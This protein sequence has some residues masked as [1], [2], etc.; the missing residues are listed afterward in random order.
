MNDSRPF[1]F[2]KL[3]DHDDFVRHNASGPDCRVLDQWLQEGLFQAARHF[4][5][6]WAD[7]YRGAS[8]YQ[9]CLQAD[10]AELMLVGIVWPSHDKSGRK[11]PFVVALRDN[12]EGIVPGMV[13]YVP[14][15]YKGFLQQSNDLASAGMNGLPLSEL[16]SGLGRLSAPPPDEMG[17][18]YQRFQDY[19]DSTTSEIFWARQ[20]GDFEDR[21]KFLLVKNLLD[22]F[23]PLISGRSVRSSLGV[24][25]PLRG[26]NSFLQE[27]ACFWILLGSQLLRDLRLFPNVLWGVPRVGERTYL[28]FFVNR[29]PVKTLIPML[30]PSVE[31]DVVYRLDE[32]NRENAA[33]AAEG[34]P[35]R[36]RL[37]LESKDLTL[38]GL[39]GEVM[40]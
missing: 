24:R 33:R 20:L 12:R 35:P 19:L 40:R 17:S 9:F 26:E 15:M 37:A 34:L 16:T 32:D 11:F 22:V 3:P 13:P 30:R 5:S 36:Y 39:L 6:D 25:F 10:A 8:P 23:G 7:V 38:R 29:P 1:F 18:T 14:V 4:S 31:S 28:Y 2:G 27:D 21:G